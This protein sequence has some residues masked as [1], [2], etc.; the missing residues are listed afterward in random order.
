MK[1]LRQVRRPARGRARIQPKPSDFITMLHFFGLL[2]KRSD[3]P[4]QSENN[5][6]QISP[7][8]LRELYFM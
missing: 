6:S 2:S 4:R 5:S 1:K 7:V 3:N 8:Y